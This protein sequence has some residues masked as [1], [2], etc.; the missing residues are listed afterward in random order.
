MPTTTN[1]GWTTPADTDLVKDGASAIRTL[2]TAI[3]TTV[4]NNAGAAIAKTIVDAKG[5][6]I[7]ATAADTIAR[8]AVGAN[9]TVL[10]ADSST[11]TGLK[12]A[13][14]GGMTLI[15]ETVAN[16]NASI[17]LSSIPSTYK[18]LL[19]IW[20]GITHSA[21]DKAWAVR[22]NNDSGSNYMI[23]YLYALGTNS[24]VGENASRTSLYDNNVTGASFGF[25]AT[26]S[27]N[28]DSRGS[29]LIDNYASTTKDKF[30]TGSWSNY[31]TTYSRFNI[32]A[33]INGKYNSTTAISSID[34]VQI[35][36]TAGTISN[37]ADTSIRL[38]GL[39]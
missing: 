35:S 36:G 5:D 8:L 24:A 30:I 11:A 16:A 19:L 18:Q 6:I 9:D 21:N 31:D 27:E 2:G 1:Y 29:L 23:G 34:I 20:C 32:T 33:N 37:R 15:S 17:S 26:G 13:A 3:D 7:A 25:G 28:G 22:F 10:T 38:Y 39:S 14:A 4:F 12:W